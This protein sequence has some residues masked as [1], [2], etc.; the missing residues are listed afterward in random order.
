[1]SEEKAT[2][3]APTAEEQ[4]LKT[5]RAKRDQERKA[6]ELQRQADELSDKIQDCIEEFNADKEFEFYIDASFNIGRQGVLPQIFVGYK[7]KGNPMAALQKKTTEKVAENTESKDEKKE[8]PAK[9]ADE[10]KDKK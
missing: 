4:K 7:P 6:K 3:K 2:P 9:E 5:E 1:M 10:V 8:E